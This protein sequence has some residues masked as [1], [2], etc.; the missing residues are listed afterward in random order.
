MPIHAELG[1]ELKE[2]MVANVHHVIEC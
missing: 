2:L 1:V